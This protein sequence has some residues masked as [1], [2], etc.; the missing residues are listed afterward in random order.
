DLGLQ[1]ENLL[2][3]AAEL[4]LGT[5]VMGIRDGEAIRKTFDIPENE[6]VVAVISVGY[7]AVDPERPKRKTVD[8]VAKFL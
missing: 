5:L 2:L 3:K 4:G 7:P 8:D 6:I 1:N